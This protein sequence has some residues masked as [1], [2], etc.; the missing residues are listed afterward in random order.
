MLKL[1][2]YKNHNYF[3]TLESFVIIF[4]TK[5][6]SLYFLYI[7]IIS[8]LMSNFLMSISLLFFNYSSNTFTHYSP[9]T[10]INIVVYQSIFLRNLRVIFSPSGPPIQLYPIIL[11]SNF[12]SLWN[13]FNLFFRY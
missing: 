5:S 9:I 11:F 13:F 6:S 2:V 3:Q 10:M 8:K 1:G 7:S 12:L 4:T